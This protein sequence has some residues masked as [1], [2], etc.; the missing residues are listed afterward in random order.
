MGSST[1]ELQQ[2]QIDFVKGAH[3]KFY[4][5]LHGKDKK[6]KTFHDTY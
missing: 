5:E 3:K 6:T 1:F 2:N 4:G